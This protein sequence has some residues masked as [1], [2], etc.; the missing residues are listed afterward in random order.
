M[1]NRKL[2]LVMT[3]EFTSYVIIKAFKILWVMYDLVVGNYRK[4]VELLLPNSK[5]PDGFR[6]LFYT[7]L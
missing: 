6:G 4:I 5:I 7:R 1:S 2:I 3:D